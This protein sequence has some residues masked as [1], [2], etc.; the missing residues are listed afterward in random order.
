MPAP[1]N[2]LPVTAEALRPGTRTAIPAMLPGALLTSCQSKSASKIEPVMPLP[3]E[4][5]VIRPMAAVSGAEMV[6]ICSVVQK[7]FQAE[8]CQRRPKSPKATAKV[9]M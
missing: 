7:L 9:V 8:P 3:I 4:L 2:R 5:T 6:A 1:P